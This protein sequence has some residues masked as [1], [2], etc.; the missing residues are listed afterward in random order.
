MVVT[1]SPIKRI[2]PRQRLPDE[3]VLARGA[4]VLDRRDDAAARARYLLVGRA[5]EPH[6]PLV[7]AVA[8]VDDVGVAIDEA[9]RHQ[10]PAAVDACGFA[11]GALAAGP[12]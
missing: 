6:A 3:F 11:G 7:G 4:H 2:E 10:P 12:A 9:G 8:G 5:L 1:P